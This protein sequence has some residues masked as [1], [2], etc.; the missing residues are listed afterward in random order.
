[1]NNNSPRAKLIKIVQS[2]RE[3][4]KVAAANGDTTAPAALEKINI[5]FKREFVDRKTACID[6]KHAGWFLDLDSDHNGNFWTTLG[7]CKHWTNAN[8]RE[9]GEPP[10][11]CTLFEPPEPEQNPQ[12]PSQ[13]PES[14][15]IAMLNDMLAGLNKTT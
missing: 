15:S 6:C 1:M 8:S 14:A 5:S 2:I 13:Q 9:F 4:F 12:N 11:F 3:D 10:M 7:V